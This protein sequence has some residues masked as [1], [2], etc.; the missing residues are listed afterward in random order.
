MWT[1]GID[2]VFGDCPFGWTEATQEQMYTYNINRSKIILQQSAQ[3]ELDKVTG[4]RGTIIRCVTA[5][6]A[7]PTS[8]T[9]Y[10]VSLRNIAN[11]TDTTSTDLPVVPTYPEGT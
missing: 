9:T 8:W 2:F 3:Q 6:V 7:I 10:I 1:N 11:G 5:G 4:P